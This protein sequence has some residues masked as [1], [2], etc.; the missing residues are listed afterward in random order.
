MG[1]PRHKT[2]VQIPPRVKSFIPEGYY[3]DETDAV[4]LEVEEYEAIRLLDYEDLSQAEAAEYMEVSRP[5]LTRIY[6]RARNKMAVALVEA[7][8]VLIDGGHAVYEGSWYKC[9]E[10]LSRFNAVREKIPSCCPLCSNETI[11]KA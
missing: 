3:A 11:E 9:A 10:C 4:V 8:K 2:K 5:T 7:R 1:R 6:E